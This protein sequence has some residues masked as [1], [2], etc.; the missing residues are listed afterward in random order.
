M[1]LTEIAFFTKDVQGTADFYQ[2]LL[3]SK[4]V[5]HSEGMSIFMAGD[6]KIFIHHHYEPK[7]GELPAENHIAF[8]VSDVDEACRQLTSQ[9]ISVEVQPEEYYWGKSAYLRAPD[10]QLV[11]LIE[12]EETGNN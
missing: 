10:G 12:A 3:D 9:G 1:K 5:A 2:A 7:D 11:E 6:T 4:P 8:T